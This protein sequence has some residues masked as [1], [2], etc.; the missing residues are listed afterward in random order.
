MDLRPDAT[1]AESVESVETGHM[2]RRC[3]PILP[4]VQSGR[5]A[6]RSMA[7]SVAGS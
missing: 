5:G 1:A 4:A 2:P 7:L 6:D 3:V